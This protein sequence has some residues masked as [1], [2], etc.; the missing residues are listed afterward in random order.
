VRNAAASLAADPVSHLFV[1][2]TL[3]RGGPMHALLEPGVRRICAARMRGRLYDL[4]AF[5]GL[6]EGRR[7][8]WVQGELYRIQSADLLD[9]LDRYEGRAYRRVVRDAQPAD[10]GTPVACWVYLFEGSLRGRRRIASGDYLAAQPDD[11]TRAARA[12]RRA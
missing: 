9:S 4:G 10:G 8:D 11:V 2:G 5:P 7:G 1:Y 6:A 3:R 12:D